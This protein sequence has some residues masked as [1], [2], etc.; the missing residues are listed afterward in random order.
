MNQEGEDPMS[1]ERNIYLG[2]QRKPTLPPLKS[3]NSDALGLKPNASEGTDGFAADR[4]GEGVCSIRNRSRDD[5]TRSGTTTASI[6]VFI[7]I[8][9]LA[10]AAW[11]VYPRFREYVQQLARVAGVEDSVKRIGERLNGV[12][13][14]LENWP[15]QWKELQRSVTGLD[16]K[17]RNDLLLARDEAR[18]LVSNAQQQLRAEFAD[19]QNTTDA[20]LD[21]LEAGRDSDRILM[22]GLQQQTESLR[23]QYAGVRNDLEVA[24]TATGRGL[25]DLRRRVEQSESGL[26][27]VTRELERDRF[28]FEISKNHA[29]EIAPGIEARI[30]RTDVRRRRFGGW[31]RLIPEGRTLWIRDQSVQ[32]P[33][34]FYSAPDQK[35]RELVITN[36]NRD[37][38][39]GYLLLPRLNDGIDDVVEERRHLPFGERK[40]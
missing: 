24:E 13:R 16:Q 2:E 12:E 15:D 27:G 30:D 23:Q 26:A 1:L 33:V 17:L 5:R 3:R 25:S 22:A 32:Q 39:A 31:I 8:A 28:D 19:N 34:V 35:P 38:V 29:L 21:Q 6:A 14:T 20:R 10:V 18:K 40:D 11:H 37:A 4:I 7:V 9:A 36:V